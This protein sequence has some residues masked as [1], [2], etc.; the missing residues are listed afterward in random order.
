M[1]FH[2]ILSLKKEKDATFTLS[3]VTSGPNSCVK[4]GA[5]KLGAPKGES[6]IKAAQPVTLVM[7]EAGDVCAQVITP[8]AHSL[9]G[10]KPEGL[11]IS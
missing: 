2:P 11:P 1:L 8:V 10:I 9:K 3:A 5:A 6:F 7:E 4:A